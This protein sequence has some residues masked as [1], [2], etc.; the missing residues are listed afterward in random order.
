M[1]YQLMRYARKKAKITQDDLAA[2]LGVNR[3]T[4][5]KYE[6][7]TIKPSISQQ[8]RIARILDID[9]FELMDDESI[10]GYFEAMRRKDH[11]LGESGTIADQEGAIAP[12][13]SYIGELMRVVKDIDKEGKLDLL[14]LSEF[15]SKFDRD[16]QKQMLRFAAFLASNPKFTNTN[17]LLENKTATEASSLLREQLLTLMHPAEEKPPQEE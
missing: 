1:N 12:V 6:T 9:I 5:S 11:A 8:L 13:D 4:I 17:E 16:N 7:G 15:F 3:A 14:L 2:L 10:R